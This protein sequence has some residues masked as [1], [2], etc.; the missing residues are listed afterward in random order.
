MKNVKD[1]KKQVIDCFKDVFSSY[2]FTFLILFIM[3]L[4]FVIFGLESSTISSFVEVLCLYLVVLLTIESFFSD[5]TWRIIFYIVGFVFA[6]VCRIFLPSHGLFMFGIFGALAILSLYKIVSKSKESIDNYLWNVFQ[7]EL[8]FGVV[9]MIIL[10][11]LL[12]IAFVIHSLLINNFT[13]DL[14]SRLSMLWVGFVFL[15]GQLLCFHYIHS[16]IFA[17][18]RIIVKYILFPLVLLT[19]GILFIYLI[20]IIVVREV[21]SNI[22]YSIILW[23]IVV[24]SFVLVLLQ[25]REVGLSKKII[26]ILPY[27][28]VILL[29]VQSYSLYLRINSYGITEMRYLGIVFILLEILV[30]L[31]IILEK[32]NWLKYILLVGACFVIISFSL[33]YVNMKNVSIKNQVRRITSIYKEGTSFDEYSKEEKE[34][35]VSAYWYLYHNHELGQ[36]PSYVNVS[37]IRSYYG[38][39]SDKY[40]EL[41]YYDDTR[42]IPIGDYKYLMEV[43]MDES[44]TEGVEISSL[45]YNMFHDV[46]GLEDGIKVFLERAMKNGKVEEKNIHFKDSSSYYVKHLS[47][48]YDEETHKVEHILM[49]GYLLKH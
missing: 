11:G 34:K 2:R 36:L 30:L 14:Y 27:L 25:R 40:K 18:V 5:K 42:E 19:T 15:P 6:L 26:T 21:P 38:D 37:S 24:G 45:S 7:N 32:L 39:N 44:F 17:I 4:L 1:Y 8:I 48:Y 31:V 22:L 12:F 33:P 47:L 13:V 9:S 20:K 29:F 3:T 23:L 28:F 16:D 35:M 41:Y 46:E 49:E 43:V 10:F